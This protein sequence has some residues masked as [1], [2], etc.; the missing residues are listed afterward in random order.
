MSKRPPQSPIS[1]PIPLVPLLITESEEEY[2]RIRQGFYDEI[3]PVGIIEKMYVDELVDIVWEI[4]RLKRCRAGVTNLN[5]HD[6][7]FRILFKL[8]QA[9]P[10]IARE[11]ISDPK[12]AK[13]VEGELATYKLDGSSSSPTPSAARPI[14]S[15]QLNSYWPHWKN[16]VMSCCIASTTSA[17]T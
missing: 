11:W 2:H 13:V 12:A 16:V 8:I 5:F 4:V 9:G 1:S 3:G 17:V 6:S 10:D 7:S 14:S 15:R